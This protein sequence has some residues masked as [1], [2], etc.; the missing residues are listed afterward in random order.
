MKIFKKIFENRFDKIEASL[1]YSN[2]ML[3]VIE[4]KNEYIE[5]LK[6]NKI[7]IDTTKFKYDKVHYKANFFNVSR[8]CKYLSEQANLVN[9]LIKYIDEVVAD[10]EAYMKTIRR[11][12]LKSLLCQP[13]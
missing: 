10:P 7:Y 8:H 11:E 1:S 5:V 3:K 2:Y 12:K 6:S 13:I 4:E 9:E